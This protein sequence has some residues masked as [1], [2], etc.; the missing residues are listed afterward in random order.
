STSAC[1]ADIGGGLT[2]FSGGIHSSFNARTEISSSAIIRNTAS[3]G[4]GMSVFGSAGSVL[5]MVN[6]TVSAN[7]AGAQAGGILLSGVNADLRF[8]TIARNRCGF[9]SLNSLQFI[10]GGGIS[11]GSGALSAFGNVM[12][13]NEIQ[14]NSGLTFSQDCHIDPSVVV[15][16]HGFNLIGVGGRDCIA[17]GNPA[18][19]TLIGG[20]NSQAL[21]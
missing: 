10:L 20:A 15:G 18:P 8:N 3:D 2:G 21:N 1:H 17:L 4:G 9:D 14:G 13:A 6:D 16:G 11:I 7:S 12:A 19:G 5:T